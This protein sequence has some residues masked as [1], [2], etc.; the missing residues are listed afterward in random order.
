[1]LFEVCDDEIVSVDVD[2]FISE[3]FLYPKL[4]IITIIFVQIK[5]MI[6]SITMLCSLIIRNLKHYIYNVSE[7]L[8]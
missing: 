8:G 2:S 6:W 3:P 5:T 1:M 4:Q 7:L